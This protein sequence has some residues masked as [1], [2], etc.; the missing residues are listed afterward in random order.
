MPLDPTRNPIEHPLPALIPAPVP[1]YLPTN[2]EK[3]VVILYQENV[4][5]LKVSYSWYTIYYEYLKMMILSR[6][7]VSEIVIIKLL[8]EIWNIL[9]Q[10][11]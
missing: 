4:C 10:L 11:L 8:P 1:L 3:E 9:F 6:T 5:N 2:Y 7:R